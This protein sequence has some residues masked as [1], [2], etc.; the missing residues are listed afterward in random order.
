MPALA[1]IRDVETLNAELGF[2]DPV[3]ESLRSDKDA[4]GGSEGPELTVVGGT[5]HQPTEA[6]EQSAA[7]AP[8]VEAA[9]E[10]SAAD[11]PAQLEPDSVEA[12][13]EAVEELTAPAEAVG[14]AAEVRREQ[15]TGEDAGSLKPEN[16]A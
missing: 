5:D 11:E 15:E 12:L 7:E 8:P 9:A 16:Q 2:T 10:E 6:G 14:E 1:E 3:P 13:A 4:E